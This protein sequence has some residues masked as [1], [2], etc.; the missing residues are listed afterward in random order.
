MHLQLGGWSLEIL[1]PC[2]PL[3]GAVTWELEPYCSSGA[4][5]V[6]HDFAGMGPLYGGYHE[7]A[8]SWD[9]HN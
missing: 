9:R 7:I 8:C 6:L 2:S 3:I 4:G 5:L 1:A